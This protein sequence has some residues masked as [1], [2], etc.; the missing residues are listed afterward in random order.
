M[1]WDTD[2]INRSTQAIIGCSFKVLNTL[3]IGF[4]EGVYLKATGLP[5]CLLLDFGN[6]KLDI[7]RYVHSSFPG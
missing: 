7:K 5:V 6:P 3:G 4:L 2:S 1:T